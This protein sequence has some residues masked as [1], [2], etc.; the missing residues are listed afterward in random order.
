MQANVRN[1]CL[2]VS[3]GSVYPLDDWQNTR[4]R[5][6]GDG[7]GDGLVDNKQPYVEGLYFVDWWRKRRQAVR[8]PP[9][10]GDGVGW[11]RKCILGLRINN[12]SAYFDAAAVF[13]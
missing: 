2:P 8:S 9:G 10:A 12:L 3:I 7:D 5:E 13:S 4:S 6:D 11:A 1:G